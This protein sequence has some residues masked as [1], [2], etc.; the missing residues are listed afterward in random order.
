MRKYIPL[1]TEGYF[2]ENELHPNR[3]HSFH[4]HR[5]AVPGASAE[6]HSKDT[7]APPTT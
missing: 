4:N 3:L 6:T 7:N 2:G 5:G 1:A